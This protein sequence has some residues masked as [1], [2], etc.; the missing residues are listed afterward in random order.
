MA[1]SL[2]AKFCSGHNIKEGAPFRANICA[3]RGHCSRL[4]VRKISGDECAGESEEIV[5]AT[6]PYPGGDRAGWA[7]ESAVGN[8][9][10]GG[11][12]AEHRH[13]FAAILSDAD[14]MSVTLKQMR[15]KLAHAEFVIDD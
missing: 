1:S 12:L 8:D 3:R 14:R 7:T 4:Q 11:L 13:R 9:H 15:Q 5:D 10:V 2:Y 6:G